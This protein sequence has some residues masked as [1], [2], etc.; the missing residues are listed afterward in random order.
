[1]RK[2]IIGLAIGWVVCVLIGGV[3]FLNFLS[4]TAGVEY[5]KTKNCKCME[6]GVKPED[7][8]VTLQPGETIELKDRK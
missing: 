7:R 3:I 8:A 2:T 6:C 5:G 1:M 4:F